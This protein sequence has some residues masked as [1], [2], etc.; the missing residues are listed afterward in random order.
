MAET[1]DTLQQAPGAPTQ[2]LA[3]QQALLDQ[4]ADQVWGF[5]EPWGLLTFSTS[6]QQVLGLV[7]WLFDHPQFRVQFL[8]DLTAVHWPDNKGGE[9]CVVYHLHSLENNLRF[10]IKVWLDINDCVVPSLTP[11]FRTANWMERETY[12]NLGVIFSGHPNLT[13]I[14]NMDDMDY[15]PLRKEFPLEDPTRRDKFDEFF[16]RD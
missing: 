5:E 7:Q 12:D 9:M 4:F 15:H 8:T 11:V 10:R 14:L 16:G 1:Q 13:R 3:L 6:R 2:N